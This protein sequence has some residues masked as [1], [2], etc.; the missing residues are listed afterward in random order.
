MADREPSSISVDRSGAVPDWLAAEQADLF[1]Q[2]ALRDA[3]AVTDIEAAQVELSVAFLSDAEMADLNAEHRDRP[4]PTNVLSFPSYEADELQDVALVM[5]QLGMPLVVGDIVFAGDVVARE[6]AEQNKAVLDHF[7]HLAVHGALHLL[8]FDHIED[9][10]AEVME[11]H[12]IAI[13]ASYNIAN[14]YL[15]GPRS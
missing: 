9:D 10:E 7:R 5:Q 2:A 13:L 12:E 11:A 1:L 3:L 14:P 6:A 4:T 8:G 15:D